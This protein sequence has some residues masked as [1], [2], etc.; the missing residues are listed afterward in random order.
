MSANTAG[1]VIT[2][3]APICWGPKKGKKY[4]S[5]FEITNRNFVDLNKLN[6]LF[7]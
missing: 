6:Q 7:E 4:F 5:L 1:K 2:C 3:R